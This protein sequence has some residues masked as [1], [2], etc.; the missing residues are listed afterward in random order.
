MGRGLKIFVGVV[1]FLGILSGIFLLTAKKK[2]TAKPVSKTQTSAQ[3]TAP[4]TVDA[5]QGSPAAG[6]VK[7]EKSSGSQTVSEVSKSQWTECK[8]KTMATDKNLFWGVQIFEAIPAGGT[9][10][11]GNLN[12]NPEFPVRVI[13][14]SDSANQEKIKGS[15]VVGKKAFLRGNCTA[16]AD[17]GAVVLQ[18]F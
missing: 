3:T 10:A 15:L 2:P 12:D 11:K 6:G 18:A 4:K 5:Q 17:D 1:V 8:N 14:K 7:A 9:Y 13:I 16:V